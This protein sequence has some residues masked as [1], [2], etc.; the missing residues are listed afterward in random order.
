MRLDGPG[1]QAVRAVLEDYQAALE[2]LPARTMV[3]CHRA[4]EKRIREIFGRFDRL[5][6]GVHVM[7]I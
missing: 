3:R 5:P 7:A 4:T 6:D 2:C 1:L